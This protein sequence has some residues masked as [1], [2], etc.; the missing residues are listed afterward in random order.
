MGH[1]LGVGLQHSLQFQQRLLGLLSARSPGGQNPGLGKGP[2]GAITRGSA[3]LPPLPQGRGGSRLLGGPRLAVALK[4]LRM[5][6][7]PLS[8]SAGELPPA[9]GPALGPPPSQG[10][11][12]GVRPQLP[13]TPGLF[14]F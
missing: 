9:P 4:V 14:L 2:P 12:S 10:L 13:P 3:C 11:L 8:V 7:E 5:E 6:M 1:H